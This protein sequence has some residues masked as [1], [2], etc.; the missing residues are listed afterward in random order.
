MLGVDPGCSTSELQARRPR[1]FTL[2]LAVLGLL[3]RV[4]HNPGCQPL[5]C[6]RSARPCAVMLLRHAA[7]CIQL[8]RELQAQRKAAELQAF[9]AVLESYDGEGRQTAGHS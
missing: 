7:V 5:S 9:V 3:R 8:L 2:S 4:G 1:H 6:R